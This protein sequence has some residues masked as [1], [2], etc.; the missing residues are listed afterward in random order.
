MIWNRIEFQIQKLWPTAWTLGD[1]GPPCCSCDLG[2]S[3][4]GQG[5]TYTQMLFDWFPSFPYNFHPVEGNDFM[6]TGVLIRYYWWGCHSQVLGDL[7]LSTLSNWVLY[8]LRTHRRH[9][10]R[11]AKTNISQSQCH[12]FQLLNAG[13]DWIASDESSADRTL[14]M[15]SYDFIQLC[16][17][18][19][20]LLV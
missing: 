2:P 8:Y 17:C 3:D 9:G 5:P 19:C 7:F 12:Q 10:N 11:F 15:L 14:W 18:A 1:K 4:G 6:R 20:V 13:S 16:L